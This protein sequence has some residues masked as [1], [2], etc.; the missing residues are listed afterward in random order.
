MKRREAAAAAS[1]A[2]GEAAGQLW[3]LA[4]TRRP[5]VAAAPAWRAL[6]THWAASVAVSVLY[7]EYG[8]YYVLASESTVY[9]YT[10][11]IYSVYGVQY[12]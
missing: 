3:W 1:L 12:G 5:E 2:L 9:I 4:R 6:S 8:V 10:Y 7:G 11:Y